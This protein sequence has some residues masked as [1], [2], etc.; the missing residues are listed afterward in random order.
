GG[1]PVILLRPDTSTADVA[2]FALAAG[3]VTSVGARTSHAAL[4]ARQMGKPCVV[5]C[6]E[7]KIDPVAKRAQLGNVAFAEGEWMTIEGDAG[8]LYLGR[9]ETI[10]TRPEAELAE[11]AAWQA[12]CGQNGSHAAAP[13]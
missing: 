3:I 5:G 12:H 1:E 13:Q 2:G 7:L 10:R 6:R 4:V 11:I 8:E 9:C